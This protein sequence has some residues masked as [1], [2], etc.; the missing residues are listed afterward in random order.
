M[1]EQTVITVNNDL[2]KQIDTFFNN[3]QIKTNA[4]VLNQASTSISG[5]DEKA[6]EVLNYIHSLPP[7]YELDLETVRKNR[8]KP[9]GHNI[10]H[11]VSSRDITIPCQNRSICARVYRPSNKDN[12]IIP[13][14]IYFHGGGFVLGDIESYDKMLAQLCSQSQISIISIAYRLAPETMFPGAV[15]D[16]QETTDWIAKNNQSLLIDPKRIAVG[17][18]SAGANLATVYCHLNKSRAD[19]K[20]FFQLLIYPSIIGNDNTKSRELFSENL[21]L[22]KELLKWFHHSYIS[23]EQENDPRFNVL[24]FKDF[25]DLPPAFVLTCGYD[26]LCD[27]GQMY[28]NRLKAN[29]VVVKHSCYSDMFHG[30]INFGVLQ[31]AKDA[32]FECAMILKGVMNLK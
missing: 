13:A 4:K 26:P 22:T 15:D 8:K 21:L 9:Y 20:P 14:L 12:D 3:G 18:D 16:T 5:L 11:D 6:T 10:T 24:N 28:V 2:K 19:F 23:K 31:Q 25:T 27:E 1:D 7:A 29:G 30:F 32:V 17:G